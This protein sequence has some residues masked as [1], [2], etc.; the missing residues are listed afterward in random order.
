MYQLTVSI[1]HCVHDMFYKH[2]TFFSCMFLTFSDTSEQPSGVLLT[3]KSNLRNIGMAKKGTLNTSEQPREA[4][5]NTSEPLYHLILGWPDW[6][7]YIHT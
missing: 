6:F 7:A 5:S 1:L 2:M 4:L 3:Y